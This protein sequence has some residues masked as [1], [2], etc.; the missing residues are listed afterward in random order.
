MKNKIT[1]FKTGDE[2]SDDFY[3]LLASVKVC[4][5]S[6]L[7]LVVNERADASYQY[8]LWCPKCKKSLCKV[9]WNNEVRVSQN[10]I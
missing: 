10:Y 6:E 7:N 9:N 2:I 3:I 1:H 8:H 4:C 5:E